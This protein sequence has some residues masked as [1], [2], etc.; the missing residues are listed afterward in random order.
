VQAHDHHRQVG[1][2]RPQTA[3]RFGPSPIRQR[4][5]EQDQIPVLLG[6]QRKRG[7]CG[8]HFADDRGRKFLR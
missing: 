6:D 5:I 4:E 7:Q 3:E 1:A 2:K 8:R